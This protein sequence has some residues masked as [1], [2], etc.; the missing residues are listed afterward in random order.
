MSELLLKNARIIDPARNI[1]EI[2]DIAIADG[3][4]NAKVVEKLKVQ[5]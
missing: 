1:D 3:E 2:G 4:L 5:S